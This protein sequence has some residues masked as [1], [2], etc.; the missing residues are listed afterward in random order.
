M[1]FESRWLFIAVL[2][3]GAKYSVVFGLAMGW[4]VRKVTCFKNDFR[5]WQLIGGK[6]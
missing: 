6:K 1:L 2:L 3:C 4:E 5:K